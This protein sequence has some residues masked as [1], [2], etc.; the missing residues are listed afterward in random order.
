MSLVGIPVGVANSTV[1]KKICIKTAITK[2]YKWI[3]KK[4]KKKHD[5]IELL[6]KTKLNT[7]KVSFS[8]VLIGSFISQDDFFQ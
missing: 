3:T 1:G 5:K 4:K 2:T 7:V 6:A 8:N